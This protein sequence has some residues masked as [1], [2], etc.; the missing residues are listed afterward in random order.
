MTSEVFGGH[1]NIRTI[2]FRFPRWFF[3]GGGG[4]VGG[5]GDF[6]GSGGI[7]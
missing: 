3:G 6:G 2:T 5:F 1:K 7:G 4:G